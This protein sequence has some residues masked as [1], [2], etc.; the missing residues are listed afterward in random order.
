MGTLDNNYNY[1]FRYCNSHKLCEVHGLP[2]RSLERWISEE[3]SKG[4]IIPGRIPIPGVRSYIWDANKFH[5]Q[6]LMPKLY[7][8][9][10]NEYEKQ[11]HIVI[12]NNLKERER[13]VV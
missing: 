8:P 9:V 2:N 11:E 6:F 1:P 13:K 7:G 3:K 12:L 5:D 4:K 10:R